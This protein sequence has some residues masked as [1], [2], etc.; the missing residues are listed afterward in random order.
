MHKMSILKQQFVI[1]RG[2]TDISWQH[3]AVCYTTFF[4]L[5][6]VFMSEC[7]SYSV[8]TFLKTIDSKLYGLQWLE[9]SKIGTKRTM[10]VLNICHRPG[11]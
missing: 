3:E 2:A 5:D 4:I 11:S 6:V 1:L 9:L 10:V 7:L 8:D